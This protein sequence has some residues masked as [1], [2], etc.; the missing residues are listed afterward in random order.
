[1]TERTLKTCE[2]L[3]ESLRAVHQ[4]AMSNNSSVRTCGAFKVR[5]ERIAEYRLDFIRVDAKLMERD[6]YESRRVEFDNLYLETQSILS[7]EIEIREQVNH[8]TNDLDLNATLNQFITQQRDVVNQMNKNSQMKLPKPPVKQF[9]GDFEAWPT[10]KELYITSIHERQ[11][12]NHCE[13]FQLLLRLLTGEA[14]E[15]VSNLPSTEIG[16][17]LAWKRLMNRYDKPKKIMANHISNFLSLKATKQLNV[18]ELRRIYDKADLALRGLQILGAQAESRDPW[19]IEILCQKIDPE[20]LQLWSI[21][22]VDDN[23]PTI[24]QFL[25]F[26]DKRC[27]ALESCSSLDRKSHN[28]SNQSNSRKSNPSTSHSFTLQTLKHDNNSTQSQ[29]SCYHCGQSHMLHR[30]LQF[31]NLD[32]NSRKQIISS[33]S[34]CYNCLRQ[35]HSVL[36]CNS[37]TNCLICNKRHHSLLH[38]SSNSMFNDVSTN[39]FVHEE[40]LQPPTDPPRPSTSSN[41][42]LTSI[43]SRNGLCTKTYSILPTALVQIKDKFGQ[44]QPA[45]ALLDS[46]SQSSFITESCVQRLGLPRRSSSIQI[47]GV[48]TSVAGQTRGDT[49]IQLYSRQTKSH[50]IDLHVLII[51]RITSNLPYSNL[52]A[53]D[54]QHFQD[55]DLADP[56]FF[57][58]A[59]IDVLIGIDVFFMLL[60]GKSIIQPN[61]PTAQLSKFGWLVAGPVQLIK[62]STNSFHTTLTPSSDQDNVNT[63]LKRFWELEEIPSS[64]Y[65]S[66]HDNVC[67][68][69]FAETTT[70]SKDGRFVV[71]IPF[72]NES[73]SLGDSKKAALSRLK[74]ME[75]KFLRNPQLKAQYVAFM[76]EYRELN[77]MELVNN[78]ELEIPDDKCFYLPHHC[79]LKDDSTT[80]KLRVVFDG[81]CKSSSGISL[82]EKMI[83]GPKIQ[84]DLLTI[85]IRFRCHAIAFAAD[86]EKMYRQIRVVKPDA[87]FQRIYWR[88][89]PGKKIETFRLLTVTYGTSCAP[90]IAIRTLKQIG[91]NI[92]KKQPETSDIIVNDFYVDDLLSGCATVE[93]ASL[94][95]QELANVL[96]E[97][98]FNIRKWKSNSEEFLSNI[99][100][101]EIE[102]T[103]MNIHDNDLVKALGICWCPANDVFSFKVPNIKPDKMTKRSILSNTSKF[104]DPMGWI[105]P[106]TINFKILLQKLWLK[107]VDWDENLPEVVHEE[108]HRLTRDI[109]EIEKIQIPRCITS[110]SAHRVELHGFCDASEMAYG[111]I[112]YCR[113]VTEN[114]ETLV[115]IVATKS[116]V[117]PIKQVSLP[118]LELCSA[119]LL[120]KLMDYVLKSLKIKVHN[121]YAWTD[122]R[123]VLHWLSDVPRRWKS[124]IG[125]RTSKILQSIPRSNWSHV[126]SKLNPADYVSRGVEANV[127]LS[128]KLYWEGPS[129]LRNSEVH[130]PQQN[131]DTNITEDCEERK[132]ISLLT[133]NDD[134]I[135]HQLILRCST[136]FKVKL[137]MFYV[138]K[139]ISIKN[140]CK[141]VPSHCSREDLMQTESKILRIVQQKH[142][143]REMEILK[144]SKSLLSSSSLSS[145][146]PFIDNNGLLRVGGRLDNASLSYAI[147]HPVIIPKGHPLVQLIIREYHINGLHSGLTLLHNTI[148]QKFWLIN[149]RVEIKRLIKSCTVCARYRFTSAQQLMGTL[150]TPRVT[151]NRPFLISGVDLAGPFNI[152]P[153]K[154]RKAPILKCYLCIFV[155]FSVKAIHVE[156][157]SDMS[158]EAFLAALRRFVSRRGVPA[159]IWCDNGRNFVGGDSELKK[160]YDIF[161][162]HFSENVL[163]NFSLQNSIDFKFIPP[164]ASHFGGLWEAAV[165]SVKFH[166]KRIMKDANL[167]FEEIS[168]L[169]CQVEAILNSRPLYAVPN[170]DPTHINVLT[171]SHFLI[172]DLLTSIPEPIEVDTNIKSLW[173]NIQVRRQSF[174][175]AWVPDYL[176]GMQ[177]RNKWKMKEP[178]L[179]I[180]DIVVIKNENL[181]PARWA[182]AR[183][184][185][186]HPGPDGQVRVATVKTEIGVFK[187]PI[188]KLCKLPVYK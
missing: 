47:N 22:V 52:S 82:N 4:F 6:D 151:P 15:Q 77:H 118:R 162:K 23:Y 102:N 173:Q 11:N 175:K 158:A 135:V 101:T 139:F 176:C 25:E 170:D 86:L 186:V 30:C 155:C 33:N 36:K 108:W 84:D 38:P 67:E 74:S 71:R 169:S 45:R 146:S 111:A 144:H 127:L 64:E 35:G 90:F 92:Q 152:K 161:I 119:Y 78:D 44:L 110:S 143:A 10:F 97:Y 70:R 1:M 136:W 160:L 129:F 54:I 93:E 95:R 182:L 24:E 18:K 168:T 128:L 69:Y 29:P 7:E 140:T 153:S 113:S 76:K 48:G 59:Q 122:S 181:P 34:L 178:N 184:I 56:S 68:N 65:L 157:V 137:V 61:K 188:S 114:N 94:R 16:Y 164:T 72:K 116:R 103:S 148:R 107:R 39:H 121:Y 147:K 89:D 9:D 150:P 8:A 179:T 159:E 132:N 100:V 130:W 62:N 105:A 63:L 117:S 57:K 163:I 149:S 28:Q 91:F 73:L 106:L 80:T 115:R 165:K 112:I 141:G 55:L 17:E 37:K 104:F 13:K 109:Y 83:I 12:L 66:F 60:D 31:R 126:P 98:G 180:N 138:L 20:T 172:G 156:V 49:T 142:F 42:A 79:V 171:P 40:Q 131:I 14:L 96:S 21:D 5:L 19:L 134:C 87:E 125:N 123:I 51:S 183:V 124:F 26:L 75:N 145:L 32:I 177:Q 185:Q 81:S 27:N 120:S 41:T 85:L 50:V 154:L 133:S 53:P 166:L 3:F 88:D 58:S 43:Q 174:W 46:G 187:R 167:T 2:L 99:P